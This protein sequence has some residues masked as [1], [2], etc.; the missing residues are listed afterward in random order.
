MDFPTSVKVADLNQEHPEYTLMRETWEN[1]EALRAGGPAVKARA[2][3]LLKQMPNEV[4]DVYQYRL[5]QMKYEPVL[6]YVAGWY[7]TAVHEKDRTVTLP[8]N[9]EFW[10]EFPSDVTRHGEAKSADDF[11]KERLADLIYCGVTY[12]MVDFPDGDAESEPRSLADQQAAGTDRAYWVPYGATDVINWQESEDGSGLEWAVIRCREVKT[13]P[14]KKPV[15]STKWYIVDRKQVAEYRSSGE[16]KEAEA[17]LEE[18]YPRA[19]RLSQA[20]GGTGVAPLL[21]LTEPENWF[22]K[23]VYD[24]VIAHLNAGSN[25]DFAIDRANHCVPVFTGDGVENLIKPR[26]PVGSISLPAGATAAYLE[27]SGKTFDIS[28]ARLARLKQEIYRLMGLVAMSRDTSA[29]AA[30]ASG[31]SKEQDMAPSNPLRQSFANRLAKFYERLLRTTATSRR[32]NEA[33]ITVVP[34]HYEDMA[35]ATAV[36]DQAERVQGLHLPSAT[37]DRQL[38]K[39]VALAVLPGADPAIADAIKQEIDSAPSAEQRAAERMKQLQGRME[40]SISALSQ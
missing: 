5:S 18:G 25:L 13:E 37:L 14:M 34:P 19:H 22:G 27:P 3:N 4:D 23:R 16:S 29:T 21:R 24:L 38:A 6:G 17:R 36:I 32:E 30:S 39:K 2:I 35:D 28:E 26:G 33:S 31:V 11:L 15:E 9:E 20:A 7:A 1:L 10:A 8:Q 12:V 40:N